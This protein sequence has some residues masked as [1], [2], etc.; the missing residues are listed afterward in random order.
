MDVVATPI[1]VG[2]LSGV[3]GVKGWVKVFSYTQPRENILGYKTWL[4]NRSGDWQAIEVVDGKVHGK[5]IIA[6]LK[7]C[8]DRDQAAALMDTEVAIKPEQLERLSKNEFYWSQL[9][10]LQVI[11]TSGEELG[12]VKKLMETGANDVLVIGQD[13]LIPFAAPQII[14]SVDLEK[15]EILVDWTTEFC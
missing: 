5:A 9:I 8:D 4:L 12:T 10:G 1:L 13:C 7:N 2:K 6:K 11:T 15:G 3:F 14:K